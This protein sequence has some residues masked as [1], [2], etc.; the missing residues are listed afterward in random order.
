MKNRY[1]ITGPNGFLAS[2]LNQV[3]NG[4]KYYALKEKSRNNISL[5]HNS[6]DE[7][8]EFIRDKKI[9]VIYHL[10]TRYERQITSE[11]I[12]DLINFNY[13]CSVKLIHACNKVGNVRIVYTTS[14][15]DLDLFDN[16]FSFYG[17]LKYRI[18]G[19]IK[20]YLSVNNNYTILRLFDNYGI[21]DRREKL[22][23]SLL[24]LQSEDTLILNSPFN[25]IYPVPVVKVLE[26]LEL[27]ETHTDNQSY[28]LRPEGPMQ[29][30]ELISIFR[31]FDMIKGRV[32]FETENADQQRVKLRFEKPENW[33]VNSSDIRSFLSELSGHVKS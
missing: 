9:N 21:G 7:I 32:H 25:V 33:C 3:L 23:P 8:A 15:H 4:E 11:N 30:Q 31:E 22:I 19:H 5:L 20:N 14:F 13:T 27:S 10:A 6:I 18:E 24:K 1:L 26:Q 29:I 17:E 12:F 28:D 2:K 16:H